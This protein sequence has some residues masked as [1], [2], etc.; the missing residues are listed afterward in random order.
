MP[1]IK[2]VKKFS[3]AVRSESAP[4]ENPH[5]E[6]SGGATQTV[7]TLLSPNTSIGQHFLKN[8][9][10]VDAIVQKSQ[11]QNTDIVLEVGENIIAVVIIIIVLTISISKVL[12]LVIL[13]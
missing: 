10:V 7:R 13:P 12:E 9:A 11:I 2:P 8:P 3:S 6:Q 1:K 4:Y 5:E